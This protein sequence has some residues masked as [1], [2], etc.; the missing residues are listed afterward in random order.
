MAIIFFRTIILFCL[1]LLAMRIMG[2]RQLGELEISELII[3]VLISNMASHPIEDIGMPLLYG[4]VPILTL[5]CFELLITG[6]TLKSIRF[7]GFIYGKPSIIVENGRINEKEM[8]KN[9]FTLDELIEELRNKDISDISK[10]KYAILETDGV[11]NTLL[12]P[13]ELPPT[14][15]MMGLEVPDG[16]K[17]VIIINDGRLLSTNLK[18]LGFNEKWL[19]KKL[20]EY[21]IKSPENVYLMTSDRSGKIYFAAKEKQ[22]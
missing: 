7:R 16:E 13:S 12:Y 1:L 21:G 22:K 19:H 2:K 15:A 17:P 4:L 5:L 6:L 8:R 18:S 3:A 20:T 11:L 10:V 9:R 14:A